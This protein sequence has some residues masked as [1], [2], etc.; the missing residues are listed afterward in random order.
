MDGVC[1]IVYSFDAGV[2]VLRYDVAVA[3][4]CGA[5]D[6]YDG[7]GGSDADGGGVFEIENRESFAVIVF[8]SAVLKASRVG[9]K[10]E[11]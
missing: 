10:V 3:N 11:S 4:R 7:E 2:V 5:R 8:Y 1:H 6:Q 9:G